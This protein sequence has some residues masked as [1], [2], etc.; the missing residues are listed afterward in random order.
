MSAH[1]SMSSG[2]RKTYGVVE[3]PDR[4]KSQALDSSSGG[5]DRM[6]LDTEDESHLGV[7]SLDM[8]AV[9]NGTEDASC[10][11]DGLSDL[12]KI[13]LGELPTSHVRVRLDH[14]WY[15]DGALELVEQSC[16]LRP[17]HG[18]LIAGDPVDREAMLNKDVF[19]F[20]SFA[21]VVVAKIDTASVDRHTAG[22]ALVLDVGQYV[23]R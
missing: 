8:D 4:V 10:E 3:T 9:A 5:V 19:S 23:L 21:K 11:L 1:V 12:G 14:D 7:V 22:E 17:G 2:R 6:K 13:G 20:S 15:L 16:V 18:E